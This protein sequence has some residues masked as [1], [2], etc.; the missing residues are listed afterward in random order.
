M[1]AAF[2]QQVQTLLAR[3]GFRCHQYVAEGYVS[4]P[5]LAKLAGISNGTLRGIEQTDFTPSVKTL[6][7]LET[8]IPS[9]Y[10]PGE[11]RPIV[12]TSVE[13][14]PFIEGQKGANSDRISS[15]KYYLNCDAVGEIDKA[16]IAKIRMATE[17]WSDA[18]GRIPEES[19][20]RDLL[21]TIAPQSA[22][23]IIRIIDPRPE[24]FQYEVW[25]T[26]TGWNDSKDFT[27]QR[28]SESSDPLLRDCTFEDFMVVR[29]FG[30]PSLTAISRNFLGGEER[31]FLRYLHP[32][33]GRD[34]SDKILCVCRPQEFQA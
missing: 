16:Q 30:W 24:G 9:S 10:T 2:S 28:I 1:H 15:R 25:D 34:G 4:R 27:G 26:G 6:A 17:Q 11:M 31:Q 12:S 19:L 14:G 3:G 22:V 21:K 23:H 33:T 5:A 18:T 32:I 8:V 7:A 29:E 13:I 20:K